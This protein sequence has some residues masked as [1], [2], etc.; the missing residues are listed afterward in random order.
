MNTASRAVIYRVSK[1]SVNLQVAL[2]GTICNI[3]LTGILYVPDLVGS[4]ILASQLADRGIIIQTTTTGRYL[5]KLKGTVVSAA[6]RIR[7]LYV[8]NSTIYSPK[9][10]DFALNTDVRQSNQEL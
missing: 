9:S 4:L 5:L 2:E 1:G 3:K 7:K 10:G 8:L 6:D